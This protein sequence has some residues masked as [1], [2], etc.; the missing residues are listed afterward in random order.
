MIS[1]LETE[2]QHGITELVTGIV[3]DAQE[4]IK[5]EFRLFKLELADKAKRNAIGAALVVGGLL[6]ISISGIVFALALAYGMVSQWPSLPL[7]GALAIVASLLLIGAAVLV[8]IARSQF[9]SIIPSAS[10]SEGK[11]N[12]TWTTK[13]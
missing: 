5:Q 6:L 13:K 2:N 1:Q 10:D 12:E 3:D 7:W 11:E 9:T 4:V 8:A